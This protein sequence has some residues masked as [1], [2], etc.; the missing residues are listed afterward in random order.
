MSAALIDALAVPVRA[1]AWLGR[2]SF[3]Q[4]SLTEQFV[5]DT[6]YAE[7]DRSE[8]LREGG[9]SPSP[10]LMWWLGKKKTGR[11]LN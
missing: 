1:L 10:L 4:S 9:P 7:L 3:S 6:Y 11:W 5:L 2:R 8:H